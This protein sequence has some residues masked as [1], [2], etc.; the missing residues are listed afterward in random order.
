MRRPPKPSPPLLHSVNKPTLQL[1][2]P[3]C[4]LLH[5]IYLFMGVAAPLALPLSLP[6]FPLFKLPLPRKALHAKWWIQVIRVFLPLPLSNSHFWHPD[7]HPSSPNCCFSESWNVL[8]SHYLQVKGLQVSQDHKS[9]LLMALLRWI[10]PV[11]SPV[12]Q[13]QVLS[14]VGT[15]TRGA[16]VQ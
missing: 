6:S 9:V 15:G 13:G 14:C 5:T 3:G 7:L 4:P 2:A 10:D 8:N 1:S 16:L 12:E 11:Q